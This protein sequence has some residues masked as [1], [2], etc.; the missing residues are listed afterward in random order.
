[1]KIY[2]YRDNNKIRIGKFHVVSTSSL[3]E[4]I[5]S[6]FSNYFLCGKPFHNNI[7]IS[8][9][10]KMDFLKGICKNCSRIY[11]VRYQK[12]L[13]FEFIKLKLGIKA[14]NANG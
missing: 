11:K 6:H 4:M 2:Q 10:N 3:N 7:D 9:S 5:S 13:N 1:M 12:D 14:G 8:N